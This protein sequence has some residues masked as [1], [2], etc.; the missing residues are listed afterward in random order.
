MVDSGVDGEEQEREREK[1]GN[2][3]AQAVDTLSRYVDEAGEGIGGARR[4]RQDGE[5]GCSCM[6]TEHTQHGDG[7]RK[8]GMCVKRTSRRD[9]YDVDPVISA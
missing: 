1:K 7:P 9:F 3:R 8:G 5:R 6:I 4:T 2:S